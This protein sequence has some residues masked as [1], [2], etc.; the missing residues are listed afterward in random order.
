VETFNL[1][2]YLIVG[3]GLYGSVCARELTDM[4]F[5]C[6][7]IDK[8]NHIGGN[9]YTEKV[10]NINVHFYGP[11]IFHTSNEKVWTYINKFITLKEYKHQ[12]V[13][14]FKNELYSL[15]FNMFTFNK[16]FG[17]NKPEDVKKKIEQQRFTGTPTNLEQQALSLVGKDT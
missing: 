17:L 9:C 16:L 10:E 8:R 7:V 4:G 14:N 15:P 13:A 1:Y 12:V 3:S 11:H 6:L 2:D 5:K